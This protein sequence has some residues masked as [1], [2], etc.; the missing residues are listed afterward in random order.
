MKK[1]DTLITPITLA[2]AWISISEFTRNE[3]LFKSHWINHYKALGLTFPDKPI[4]GVIW[5]I[6]SLV[7]AVIIGILSRKFSLQQ[8]VMISWVIGFFMMWLV[9]GNLGVLPFGLIVYALPLSI[10]EVFVAAY[11]VK[12]FN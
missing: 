3:I 7:F 9:I 12:K 10:L 5:G 4:N 6:W 11:I 2:T 1:K 8:T